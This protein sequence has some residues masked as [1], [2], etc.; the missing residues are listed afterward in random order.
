MG[1][2]RRAKRGGGGEVGVKGNERG[3]GVGECLKRVLVL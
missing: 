1:T 3:K 2:T